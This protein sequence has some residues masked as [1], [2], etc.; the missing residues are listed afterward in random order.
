MNQIVNN[1]QL[2]KDDA[3]MLV[4]KLIKLGNKVISANVFDCNPKISRLVI[5]RHSK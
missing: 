1:D 2:F 5:K 4:I 3:V